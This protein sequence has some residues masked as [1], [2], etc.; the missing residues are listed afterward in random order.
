MGNRQ[1]TP[2]AKTIQNAVKQG[3]FSRTGI[4]YR[5]EGAR[6]LVLL[7]MPSRRVTWYFHYDA[8]VGKKRHRRKLKLG[9]LDAMPLS[10]ALAEAQRLRVQTSAG[11]DPVSEK[12]I[13]RNALSFAELANRRV[14]SGDLRPSTK[15]EYRLVLAKDVLPVPGSIPAGEITREDV[16]R[17]IE[18]EDLFKG[19]GRL[20]GEKMPS[21]VRDLLLESV[22]GYVY[23]LGSA[24]MD[25]T[26]VQSIRTQ[27][28]EFRNWQTGLDVSVA[29]RRH[30]Y[31]RARR[32]L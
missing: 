15:Q 8:E 29:R 18:I 31:R 24:N 25:A 27:S 1:L 9:R 3:A 14:E 6:G 17:V 19:I 4:E 28:D 13:R 7:V 20:L 10:G 5:I 22:G 30:R 2:N 16:V 12:T 26:G 32:C 21:I 11:C 23:D